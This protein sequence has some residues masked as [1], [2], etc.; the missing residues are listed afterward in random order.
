VIDQLLQALESAQ[1]TGWQL[2]AALVVLIAAY[3][4]G[5]L[6]QKLVVRTFWRVP[7]VPEV[8]VADVGRRARWLIYLLVF[9]NIAEPARPRR[10]FP[11]INPAFDHQ[12]SIR[13]KTK[14]I[15]HPHI[16]GNPYARPQTVPQ[17]FGAFRRSV[18][19][20]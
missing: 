3:P 14:A 2:L 13:E 10:R 20:A 9:G 5:K 15:R 17:G 8:L 4:I 11:T 12:P 1:I 18:P 19:L 7:N 6:V 16:T